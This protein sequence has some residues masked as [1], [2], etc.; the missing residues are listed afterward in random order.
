MTLLKYY[1]MSKWQ[2]Y[3]DQKAHMGITLS[4]IEDS[5]PDDEKHI[6]DSTRDSWAHLAPEAANTLWKRIYQV[7]VT[8]FTD[9]EEGGVHKAALEIYNSRYKEFRA[10]WYNDKSD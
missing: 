5:L 9:V 6:L 1:T 10:K 4:M 8:N 2:C 3:S 7:M